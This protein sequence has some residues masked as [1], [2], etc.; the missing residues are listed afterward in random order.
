MTKTSLGLDGQRHT[1]G[2]GLWLL[3]FFAKLL[4]FPAMDV[5]FR[6]AVPVRLGVG[7]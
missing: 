6:F 2:V 7:I 5:Y 4:P 3:L 1:P